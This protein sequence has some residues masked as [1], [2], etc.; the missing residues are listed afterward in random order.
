MSDALFTQGLNELE[1][2]PVLL[3]R[4]SKSCV[5][6]LSVKGSFLFTS[7]TSFDNNIY[8]WFVGEPVLNNALAEP[9]RTLKGTK[10][11]TALILSPDEKTLYSAYI[12]KT[13]KQWDLST[14][15]P[16]HT[17]RFEN[18]VTTLA[19]SP[20]GKT[21]YCVVGKNIY[22][23]SV[24]GEELVGTLTAPTL[25]SSKCVVTPDGKRLFNAVD[26]PTRILQWDLQTL[27]P[28][29]ELVERRGRQ[30][31]ICS[32]VFHSHTDTL[33]TGNDRGKIKLWQ[34]QTG[35]VIRKLKHIPTVPTYLPGP[36]KVDCL[37]V[38]GWKL[39]SG[40]TLD[41]TVCIWDLQLQNESTPLHTLQVRDLLSNIFVRHII[42]TLPEESQREQEQAYEADT[43][44]VRSD[45]FQQDFVVPQLRPM[46]QAHPQWSLH[47]GLNFF[48]T[49]A[50]ADPY[51]PLKK[52]TL[53]SELSP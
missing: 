7:G 5:S 29:K 23:L 9:Y 20:E 52:R 25:L 19:L 26:W 36:V 10:R 18:G 53:Q 1:K 32:M 27:Q 6:C 13:V 14:G 33:I 42:Q 46:L 34:S 3:R 21:L 44:A 35:A 49:Q 17:V 41:T 37:V 11:V 24:P 48:E 45:M 12:D 38:D 40:S 51:R 47:P 28:G 30:Y 8:Q 4:L 16:V 2:T 15:N 39:F 31:Q 22:L 43:R 50:V